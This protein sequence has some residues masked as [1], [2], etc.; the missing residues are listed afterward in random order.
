[1]N[2]STDWLADKRKQL[3]NNVLKYKI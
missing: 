3:T 1:L 2:Q